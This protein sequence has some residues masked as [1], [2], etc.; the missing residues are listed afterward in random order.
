MTNVK[1]CGLKDPAMIAQA[2]K[3]GADWIGLMLVPE[4]PRNILGDGPGASDLLY[5]LLFAAAEANIRSVAVLSDP[6]ER[7]LRILSGAVQPDVFQM[8]GSETPD[9]IAD[10]RS[11]LPP[12][13]E[14]W[15]AIGVRSHEDLA[16]CEAYT[17][18]DRL[19]IDAKAPE[20]AAYSGGHGQSFDWSI[21]NHWQAPKPWILAGG[22]TPGN[23]ASAIAATGATAVD[24]S[25]GV[26]R[27][28]GV[29]D[30]ALIEQF[31]SAA[32]AV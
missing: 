19:L 15:K 31:I 24:V 9:Q 21:L 26:E 28:R 3:A 29:K 12:S 32:K 6:D 7:T 14:V 16:Q 27:E 30:A 23:V 17:H 2:A 4:S 11:H 25:S 18:A 20:G 5:D 1:I 8:H 22:L 13:I 10:L